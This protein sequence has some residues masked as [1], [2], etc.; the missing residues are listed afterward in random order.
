[1][2]TTMST[3]GESVD[4]IER[5]LA[6][7]APDALARWLP[8]ATRAEITAVEEVVGMPFPDALVDLL[9]RH[10]GMDDA[11]VPAAV[12]EF[13]PRYTAPMAVRY[14]GSGNLNLIDVLKQFGTDFDD[15]PMV[16]YWWHPRWLPFGFNIAANYLFVDLRPDHGGIGWFNH[17]GEAELGLA[18]SLEVF[19]HDVAA[20]MEGNGTAI[21]CRPVIDEH[22]F[23]TW[24]P[25]TTPRTG[26]D[27]PQGTART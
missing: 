21:G 26:E 18:P 24:V 13:L 3:A 19:L 17:E 1:M 10:N 8:P 23:V 12:T 20:A 27:D 4:R 9:L 11:G 7:H 6:G 5:W 16:G 2:M 25:D 14:I 22:G 15:N